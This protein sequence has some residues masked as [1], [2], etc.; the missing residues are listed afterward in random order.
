[1]STSTSPWIAGFGFF[2]EGVTYTHLGFFTM[3]SGILKAKFFF[4][5]G[6][7]AN[8]QPANRVDKY[9]TTYYTNLFSCLLLSKVDQVLFEFD[10]PP[11]E[12]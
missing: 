4:L 6:A 2:V 10:H 9:C 1:M 8:S 7:I 3:F 5:C 11:K 12:W